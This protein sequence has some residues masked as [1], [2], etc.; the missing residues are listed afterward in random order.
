MVM[1]DKK[2]QGLFDQ[3]DKVLNKIHRGDLSPDTLINNEV[4]ITELVN[5]KM[6]TDEP[7]LINC[8]KCKLDHSIKFNSNQLIIFQDNLTKGRGARCPDCDTRILV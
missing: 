2:L 4:P 6:M 5:E 7:V 8:P 3:I 1:N